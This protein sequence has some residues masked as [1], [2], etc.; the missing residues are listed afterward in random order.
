MSK[1]DPDESWIEE[2]LRW[3][4][5]P[6]S[7][8]ERLQRARDIAHACRERVERHDQYT[9][10]HSV[11]VARLSRIIARR[12]PTFHRERL[13]KLEITAL[14]HDFGKIDVPAEILNKNGPL[15]DAEV[16][17]VQRHPVRGAVRLET[18][19]DF[20]MMD[21]VLY[22]HVRYAGGGY[23]DGTFHKGVQIPIE[24]RIIA[25]ADMFDALTS[26]RAYR[27]GVAPEEALQRMQ[28]ES[29]RQLDPT[30]LQIFRD[31]Y[32]Q[33]A[34]HK[35]YAPGATTLEVAASL[36]EEIRRALT[37]LQRHVGTFNYK[38]PLAAIP[39]KAAFCRK[40]V[41]HLV[42]L[43]YDRNSAETFVRAAYHLPLEET[44]DEVDIGSVNDALHEAPHAP[45]G[46]REVTIQLRE[47][48]PRYRDLPIA[49]FRGKVWK[50]VA[51]GNR[52]VL[53]R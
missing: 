12:L 3:L 47:L 4:D 6:L 48:K 46:H 51:D 9:R 40:A 15:T 31:Y 5:A 39:D 53:L 2:R 24:A 30:L 1:H 52:M 16:T 7:Y 20:V 22:H 36:G 14:V 23:P 10:E 19:A 42:S 26:D 11:R 8:E 18:F 45:A 17:A 28:A 21:G 25:V 41:E 27:K 32:D 34:F 49:V 44:F 37:F 50:C 38:E 33:E 29:G 35:G 43:T 13:D